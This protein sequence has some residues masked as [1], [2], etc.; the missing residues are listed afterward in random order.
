MSDATYLL[1]TI[2][3]NRFPLRIR[4]TPRHVCQRARYSAQKRG[5]QMKLKQ[6]Q[7][8]AMNRVQSVEV[9]TPP[10]SSRIPCQRE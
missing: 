2:V 3:P 7:L 5:S 4:L 8:E 9:A 10:Y 6:D 1:A